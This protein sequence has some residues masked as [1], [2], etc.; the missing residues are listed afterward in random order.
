VKK[1]KEF[2]SLSF[3]VADEGALVR[4]GEGRGRTALCVSGCS[5]VTA[6]EQVFPLM[7]LCSAAPHAALLWAKL[8]NPCQ[9]V[10]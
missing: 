5:P 9:N 6:V 7:S 4:R 2:I 8:G 10:S 3:C 1:K